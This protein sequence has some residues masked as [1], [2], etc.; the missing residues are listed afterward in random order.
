MKKVIIIGHFWPYR[1]DGSCRM[2]GLAKWLKECGIEPII[3]TG[4][5]KSEPDFDVRYIEVDYRSFLGFKD[6]LG[7]MQDKAKTFSPKSKSFL[8]SVFNLL[9]EFL[10]YP[11]QDKYFKNPALKEASNIIESEKI[12]AVI[13]V[14]PMTGHIVAKELKRKYGI[15]W[16]ADFPELWTQNCDY[17][18]SPVRK[19]FERKLELKTLSY[20]DVFTTIS[21]PMAEELKEFHKGKDVFTIT[22]GFNPEEVNNPKA[23]L[24]SKFT[25]THTGQ[26]YGGKRD[27]LKILTAL[28]ELIS[29]GV[30]DI[31]DVELRFYGPVY[32]KLDE[33]IKKLGLESCVFQ[34]GSVNRSD[35]LLRQRESQILLLLNWEDEK[36]KGVYTGK[37]FEYLAARRPI[38]ATGGYGGD[39]VEKLLNETKAGKSGKDITEIKNILK[40]FYSQYKENGE[41][42][43]N[44]DEREIEKYSYKKKAEEFCRILDKKLVI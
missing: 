44:P 10:A 30:I 40:E 27:P 14:W 8:L 32:Y 22:H 11:D 24:T 43:Y 3:I 5:L 26:M 34:L 19:F 1:K 4:R 31:N 18:F 13:S 6:S 41:V 7:K 35:S 39:V 16:I 9:R 28:K 21:S 15:L 36:Q 20:A 25:I 23:K 2:L 12:S 42:I 38:I 33:E 29:N 17:I 37:I